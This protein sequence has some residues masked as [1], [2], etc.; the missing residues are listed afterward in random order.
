[1]HHTFRKNILSAFILLAFIGLSASSNAAET[2]RFPAFS[3]GPVGAIIRIPVTGSISISG[4]VE[5]SFA[6]TPTVMRVLGVYGGPFFAF[7]CMGRFNPT[8]DNSN[9][10]K[11]FYSVEC[12]T[13]QPTT[14]GPLFEV[15]VQLLNGPDTTGQIVVSGVRSDG[16]PITG[17]D[18]VG[19]TVN[20]EGG[21][22]VRPTIMEGISSVFPNPVV[23]T[24]NV[25]FIS[26]AAGVVKFDI[27][28]SGGRHAYDLGSVFCTPGENT[29]QFSPK[30]WEISQGAVLLRM[31]TDNGTYF[32]PVM[33]VK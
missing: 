11:A 21:N 26:L 9:G 7:Q 8:Q 16:I 20:V 6:Y 10:T 14:D 2:F 5:V 27:F 4:I 31:K 28:S 1:M 13:V 25:N 3:G 32:Y 18:F 17:A 30:L 12:G 15:E 33:V 22:T 24:V 29:F 23:S 19:G